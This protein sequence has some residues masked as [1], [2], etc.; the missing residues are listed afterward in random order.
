MAEDNVRAHAG[1]SG[2][3]DG[4]RQAENTAAGISTKFDDALNHVAFAFLGT[5]RDITCR[6]GLL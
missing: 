3:Q 1:E 4:L 5:V 6:N 2:N